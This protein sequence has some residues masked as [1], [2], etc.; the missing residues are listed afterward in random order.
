MEANVKVLPQ[1]TVSPICANHILRM[2]GRLV[3]TALA[4]KRQCKRIGVRV[5]F[6]CRVNIQS[7]WADVPS[8]RNAGRLLEILNKSVFDSPCGVLSSPDCQNLTLGSLPWSKVISLGCIN[9]STRS[10]ITK[11]RLIFPSL[12][13]SHKTISSHLW[14]SLR[15]A[16]PMPK[17]SKI[18]KEMLLR[19]S[20]RPVLIGPGFLSTTRTRRFDPLKQFAATRLWGDSQCNEQDGQDDDVPSRPCTNDNHINVIGHL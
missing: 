14:Q 6:R 5:A 2:Y 12:S 4:L 10:G 15:I 11:V 20:A 3:S 1:P 18:S 16:S 17:V 19:P 8:H 13:V 7:D 9:S